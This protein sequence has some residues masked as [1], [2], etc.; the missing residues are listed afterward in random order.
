MAIEFRY[1]SVKEMYGD[2]DL[3]NNP[4]FPGGYINYGDWENLD[5][6]Q[7]I[8]LNTR[9]EASAN[10]YRKILDKMGID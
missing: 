7:E 3:G 8:S 6:Q 4:I 5:T 1:Q 10:L 2:D 9:V